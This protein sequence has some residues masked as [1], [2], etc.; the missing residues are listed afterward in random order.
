MSTLTAYNS[1]D[2]HTEMHTFEEIT[3]IIDYTAVGNTVTNLTVSTELG[4]T[5]AYYGAVTVDSNINITGGNLT[6]FS[7]WDSSGQLKV[8]IDAGSY[9]AS[10]YL[11]FE[12]QDNALGLM[13]DVLSGNDAMIG[14]TGSDRLMAFSGDDTLY[15]GGAA[16]AAIDGNDVLLGGAGSDTIYGNAGDDI[17]LG[18]SN[19]FDFADGGDT[20]YGG[21]GN[22]TIYAGG[23]ND[24][25]YGNTGND[26]IAMTSGNDTIT[27][28]TGNDIFVF[29]NSTT[30]YHTI[31][32]FQQG[33]T[34]SI[35]G[36][37]FS[38]MLNSAVSDANGT[39]LGLSGDSGIVLAGLSTLELD[40]G[41]F[42]FF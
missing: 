37:D 7:E 21:L 15:G 41:D 19:L 29:M 11:A 5:Q 25:V 31:T 18:G 13:A 28:G 30:G 2:Q 4:N 42:F 32:D 40:A 36:Q 38:S 12:A 34:L 24:V 33:D 16:T 8:T 3:N 23:G 27:G 35:Q 20:I 26:L 10:S 1:F 39:F 14:S 22:D 17:L 6:G 9:A